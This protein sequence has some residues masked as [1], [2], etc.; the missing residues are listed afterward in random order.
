MGEDGLV[1]VYWGQEAWRGEQKNAYTNKND[2]AGPDLVPMV[3][4]ISPNIMF[5]KKTKTK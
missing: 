1:W 4:E 2:R 5:D 3:G